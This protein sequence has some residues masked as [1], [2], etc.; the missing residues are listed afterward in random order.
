MGIPSSRNHRAEPATAQPRSPGVMC[1][2]HTAA[3]AYDN[4]AASSAALPVDKEQAREGSCGFGKC[5]IVQRRQSLQRSIRRLSFDAGDIG[6]RAVKRDQVGVRR[7]SLEKRVH[8]PAIAIFPLRIR[9]FEVA[10]IAQF[11][12]PR[13]QRRIH[14]GTTNLARQQPGNIQD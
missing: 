9:P 2:P 12:N 1:E 10:G 11:G 5:F 3:Y 8:A 13:R 7:C 14:A 6:V 4:R